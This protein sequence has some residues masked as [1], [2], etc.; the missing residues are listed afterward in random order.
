MKKKIKIGV[1][2]SGSGSNLQ[3]IINGCEKNEI[4]GQI[5]FVGTD[6]PHAKGLNRA[7]KHNVPIVVVDYPSIF[8]AYHQKKDNSL[9]P[10]DFDFEEI[11]TK[12]NLFSSQAPHDEVRQFFEFRAIAENQLL[13]EIT[14]YS[15]D[16][17]VLAGFMRIL[18]PYFIDRINI[19]PG[20]P[21]I[22]NIHP[23]LLPAFPGADG[24]GETYRYGC[25]V[26]GCTVHFVDYGEDTGPIIGQKAFEI[27]PDETLDD[28]R[29]K[30][31][32]MEWRLYPECIQL[33]AENR[34]EVI[35][36]VHPVKPGK[37][38]IQT[39]VKILSKIN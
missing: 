31:L 21:R 25:K 7:K 29:K 1:L 12:Q 18:S 22:M 4:D 5:C 14:S 11:F 9:N 13:K 6:N 28:I 8:R 16:L 23:A 37:T 39:L 30:G 19:D 15:F 33:F 3:A 36:N 32:E 24:Y 38:K 34:L 2:I 35:P 27:F 10:P 20:R 17:L 26:G